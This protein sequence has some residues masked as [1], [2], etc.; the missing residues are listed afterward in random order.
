[1]F[2]PDRIRTLVSMATVSLHRIIMEK[3]LWPLLHLFDRKSFILAG[4]EDNHKISD[5]FEFQ[6]DP[7]SDCRVI[8]P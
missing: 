3:T 7:I 1:M 8:C 2:L 4:H 6:P 5:E